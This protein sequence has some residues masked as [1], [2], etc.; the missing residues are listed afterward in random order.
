MTVGREV[1]PSAFLAAGGLGLRA[2]LAP[3]RVR[4]SKACS[5]TGL[6]LHLVK[7]I[8]ERHKGQMY[9]QSEYGHGSTFGFEL[10]LM[11]GVTQRSKRKANATK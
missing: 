8:I 5:G 10:P 4:R 2:A 11:E 9:F 6:G 3:G 7:S 1:T